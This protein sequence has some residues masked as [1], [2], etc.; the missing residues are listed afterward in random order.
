[1]SGF[2]VPACGSTSISLSALD[3]IESMDIDEESENVSAEKQDKEF[4]KLLWSIDDDTLFQPLGLTN[5]GTDAGKTVFV[6][7]NE[8]YLL[9][10]VF[11]RSKRTKKISLTKVRL[12]MPLGEI[13]YDM[14][15]LEMNALLLMRSGNVYYF[16]SVKSMHAIDWLNDAGGGVR[17]MALA[18]PMGFSCIRYVSAEKALLLEMYQDVPDIGR[19]APALLQRC[20]ITFDNTNLFNCSWEDERYTLVSQQVTEDNLSF[21]KC[22]LMEEV[23][24]EVGQWLHVFTVSSNVFAMIVG[25]CYEALEKN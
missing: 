23:D 4:E 18:P 10:F 6:T 16:S 1:M 17:C 13:A 5:H 14:F 2:K 8:E 11:K 12:P 15:I 24:L 19:S 9:N 7:W 22:L 25:T 3:P 21:I 20:D